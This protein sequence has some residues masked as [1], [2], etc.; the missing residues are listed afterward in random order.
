VPACPKRKW[1]RWLDRVPVGR[2]HERGCVLARH[3]LFRS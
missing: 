1:N 2:Y 3:R